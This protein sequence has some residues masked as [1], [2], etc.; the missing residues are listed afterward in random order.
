MCLTS[1]VHDLEAVI[2]YV[3]GLFYIDAERIILLGASQGGYV[4]GLTAAENSSVYRLIML[5]PALCIPDHA[6]RGR[7]GG[8]HYDVNHVP[9][10]IDCGKTVIGR[11]FHEDVV[12]RDPN[13]DLSSFKGDVLLIHGMADK[14]VEYSYSIRASESYE[15]GQCHLQLVQDMGHSPD[16]KQKASIIASIRQFL[17]GRKEVMCFRIILTHRESESE[18]EKTVKKIFFTGYCDSDYYKGTILPGGVDRQTYVGNERTDICAEYEFDGVDSSGERCRLSV[19]NRFGE[20]DWEPK[21]T[22]D[23]STLKWMNDTSFTAV[24]EHGKVGPVIRVFM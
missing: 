20:K 9:E 21:I 8:A 2:S 22:T 16:D 3:R 14:T 11:Q 24:I 6:R 12:R 7:L 23:S 19:I 1:E 13:L 4:A 10:E 15:K 5:Y 18:G 17:C